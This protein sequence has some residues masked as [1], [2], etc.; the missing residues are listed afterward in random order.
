M[1]ERDVVSWNTM[2]SGSAGI[3]C[4]KD[5]FSYYCQMKCAG[6]CPSQ[7]SFVSVLKASVEMG[8]L[9]ICRQVHGESF[10]YGLSCDLLVGNALLTVY[11]KL[12]EMKKSMEVLEGMHEFDE[13]SIEILLR[14]YLHQGNSVCDA[15][16][17]FRYSF[18]S[19]VPFSCYALSSLLSLCSS[20]DGFDHGVQIHGYIVKDGLSTNVSIVNSLITMYARSYYLDD[21]VCLFEDASSRD[22]V[23]WNSLIAGYAFNSRGEDGLGLLGWFMS[24][25]MRLNESTFSSLLSCCATVTSLESAKEAHALIIKLRESKDVGIDNI[26][27]TMYCKR[28]SLDYASRVFNVL[29]ERDAVSYN[30]M[31][32]LFRNHGW[33]E[34]SM[35][36]LHLIQLEGFKVDEFTYSSLISSCSRLVDLEVG[37]QIHGCIMTT[38]FDM[39]LPLGNS[40]LEMYS[41][42]GQLKDME[43]IVSEIDAP[44]VFT[45]N[46]MVMAYTSFGFFDKSF[47]LWG[48]MKESGVDLNEFSYCAMIDTCSYV[49]APLVGEQIHARIK[50]LGLGSDTT[51]MNSMITMYSSCEKMEKASI[52]FEE[53]P[54]KDYV[55]WNAL[56]C[57]CAQ[58]GFTE[59]AVK[60]YVLMNFSGFKPNDMTFASIFKC[61]AHHS[62]LLLS[63]QFHAEVIKTGFESDVAISN[64][65]ITIE[66]SKASKNGVG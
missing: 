28:R 42:C 12:G 31:T 9:G 35:R 11:V 6:V 10:K 30:L 39:I 61:C 55:S 13:I 57:G 7:S 22:I 66:N 17:L 23:T 47:K 60:F 1:P 52:I 41:Q 33:Y 16:E 46:I 58:N 62:M 18:V 38:G 2:I 27:L 20:V 50:K 5:G 64:S 21:A 63:L 8:S 59:E 37:Q 48:K 53:I 45:W 44:D 26:I 24:S 29:D 65:I 51:L 3:G 25:G 32:G 19:Q 56:I 4:F 36:V 40:L 15:F 43:K 49:E 34:E 14:G 54:L